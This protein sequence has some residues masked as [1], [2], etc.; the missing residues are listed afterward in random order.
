MLAGKE[1]RACRFEAGLE[2]CTE[3]RR[4]LGA[5]E[6]RSESIRA[7]CRARTVPGGKETGAA[8]CG[9]GCWEGTIRVDTSTLR[10]VD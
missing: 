9:V 10:L 6:A 3:A 7:R 8:L 5:G 4:A 1:A 2:E